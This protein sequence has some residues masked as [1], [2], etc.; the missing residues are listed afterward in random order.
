MVY[1]FC[2]GFPLSR[3]K[4]GGIILPPPRAHSYTIHPPNPKRERGP[5]DVSTSDRKGKSFS[6]PFECGEQ[7]LL[8]PSASA[9]N[10]EAGQAGRH[11]GAY[12]ERRENRT[13][14]WK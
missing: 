9:S 12:R 4:K 10:I 5:F 13:E 2:I 11:P 6:G 7:R 14:F 1:C 3:I 8:R